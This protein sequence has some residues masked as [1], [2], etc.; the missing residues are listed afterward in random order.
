M[1]I[2]LFY[3]AWGNY[4]KEAPSESTVLCVYGLET[5]FSGDV[6]L[7]LKAVMCFKQ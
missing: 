6:A 1:N 7:K 2:P 3:E 4:G 5:R